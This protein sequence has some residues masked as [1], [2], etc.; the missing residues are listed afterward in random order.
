M[1][2]L[3]FPMVAV[4]LAAALV[5]SVSFAGDKSEKADKKKDKVTAVQLGDPAPTFSLQ[6]QDGK[7][8]NLADHAGK[9]VVLEW[10][11]NE[12]PYVVKH[13][14]KGDMQKLADKYEEKGVVWLAINTTK[15]KTNADN[16]AIASEWKID[17]PILN[18]STGEVGRAYGAKTTP[19]MYI[20]DKEGKVVYMGAIDNDRS[21]DQSKIASATNYVAKALDEVLAG[22]SVSEPQTKPYGCSV[23]YASK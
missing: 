16:K 21:S 12:C 15:G 22:S 6:D 23:K 4:A 11:N 18:D 17:R 8:V 7:T 13:Y 3:M 2:K 5:A 19:H 10:F 14:S 9:I 20:L 1:R